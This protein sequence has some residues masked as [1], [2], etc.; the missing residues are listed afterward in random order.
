[1]KKIVKKIAAFAVIAALLVTTGNF[2]LTRNEAQAA[3]NMRGVWLSFIDQQQ[4]LRG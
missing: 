4:F 3:N 1:M 2:G